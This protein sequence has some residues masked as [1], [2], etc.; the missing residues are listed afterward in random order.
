MRLVKAPWPARFTAF[1]S[2]I[3][4]GDLLP[5]DGED[6]HI[7]ELKNRKLMLI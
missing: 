7:S 3:T 6:M 5:R 2:R 4:R 1:L